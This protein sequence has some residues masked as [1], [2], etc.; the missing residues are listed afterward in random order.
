MWKVNDRHL[1]GILEESELARITSSSIPQE[2][3]GEESKN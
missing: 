1:T 3:C 2:K